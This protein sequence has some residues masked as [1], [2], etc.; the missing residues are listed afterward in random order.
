M[1]NYIAITPARDE[2]KL[3][4]GLIE[5]MVAQ[6]RLPER[7]II[8]DDGSAD[9]TGAII[10][11]SARIYPWIKA[12]HLPRERGRAPGGESVVMQFLPCSVWD[13]HDF[14][15]RLDADL[16]FG[17]D[18]AELLLAEFARDPMLGIAGATLYEHDKSRWR[19]IRSPAFHTRGAIKMYSSACFAAIHG[20]EGGLGWDTIDEL[21]AMMAGF[22][23]RSFPHIHAFHHRPQGAAGGRL[24]ARWNAGYAAYQSGYSALFMIARAVRQALQLRPF[25]GAALLL[26]YLWPQLCR[27]PR[28][29]SPEMV[30]F[31]RRQ[32]V[33]R[34]LMME[35]V[36][37]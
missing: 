31:V 35:S 2:E 25:S 37:R 6:T 21:R 26:G 28:A 3:L 29:A 23:T 15:L 36:W 27:A 4:F 10:D 1:S 32:Q 30:R 8:I 5:S 14:I 22:V 24:K 33:R 20:L 9:S 13:R 12:H 16:T 19:E 17:R 11:E 34:L 18:F 7:W